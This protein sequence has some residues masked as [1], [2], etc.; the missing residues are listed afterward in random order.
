MHIVVLV[1]GKVA[2]PLAQ[3]VLMR[4]TEGA[5]DLDK[6]NFALRRRPNRITFS[7]S[8]NPSDLFMINLL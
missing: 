5:L 4:V 7:R 2:T 1:L 8:S 6:T 3:I